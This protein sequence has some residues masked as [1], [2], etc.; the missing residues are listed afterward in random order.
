MINDEERAHCE[1]VTDRIVEA[2][3]IDWL[4]QTWNWK[5]VPAIIA[6]ERALAREHAVAA[7]MQAGCDLQ[8]KLDI[9]AHN[10]VREQRDSVAI[11]AEE[12]ELRYKMAHTTISSLEHRLK[13]AEAK[14]AAI[15]ALSTDVGNVCGVAMKLREILG[16]KS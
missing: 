13:A 12:F 6:S 4:G 9:A 8:R 7:G 11:R 5:A 14:L 10:E 1:L 16:G 2:V 3:D 15:E